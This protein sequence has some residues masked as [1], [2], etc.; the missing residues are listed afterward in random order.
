MKARIWQIGI[1]NT[2]FLFILLI[3]FDIGLDK[4]GRLLR[5]ICFE[6]QSVLARYQSMVIPY[7]G[8]VN[9][10]HPLEFTLQ[11]RWHRSYL[12]S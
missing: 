9:F 6:S 7:P 3:C 1:M 10:R 2:V 11:F 5:V 12:K 4:F 8:L